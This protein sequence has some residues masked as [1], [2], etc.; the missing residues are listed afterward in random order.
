M[1]LSMDIEQGD[2]GWVLRFTGHDCLLKVVICKK[3]QDVLQQLDDHFGWWKN[4]KWT[5]EE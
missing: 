4:E 2:N 3:W 5:K 1:K